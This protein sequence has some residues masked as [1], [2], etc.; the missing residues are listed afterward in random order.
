MSNDAF[1][2]TPEPLQASPF[3]MRT[4]ALLGA[5][6]LQR[7]QALHILVVGVGAVGGACARASPRSAGARPVPHPGQHKL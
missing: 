6:A 3:L 2:Q 5:A 4:E 7:L 1:Q